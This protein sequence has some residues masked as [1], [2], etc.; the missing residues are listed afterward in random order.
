MQPL[1]MPFDRYI[2]QFA[3]SQT[4]LPIPS[5]RAFYNGSHFTVEAWLDGLEEQYGGI[6]SALLWPTYTN[7]GAD[8]PP[9]LLFL[10][11]FSNPDPDP[12]QMLGDKHG[13]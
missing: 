5:N 4:P 12:N 10:A 8:G 6:D 13:P 3:S 11:H 2:I 9:P 1:M 7:I